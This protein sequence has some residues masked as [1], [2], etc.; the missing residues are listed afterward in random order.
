M[1]R[2]EGFSLTELLVVLG[3]L[4]LVLAAVTVVGRRG[5]ATR[6]LDA[7]ARE[8]EA[9][10]NY[11]RQASPNFGGGRVE[12]DGL[13]WRV[14]LGSRTTSEGRLPRDLAVTLEPA[15][16][17]RVEFSAAGTVATQRTV[18]L[19]SATTGESRQVRVHAGT[20]AVERLS[21]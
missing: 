13:A 7:G 8:V 4:A 11:A 17:A 14:V 20:G 9:A 12:F 2:R 3:I 19:T 6:G 18:T 21:P 1:S 16:P 5:S 10:L 15:S